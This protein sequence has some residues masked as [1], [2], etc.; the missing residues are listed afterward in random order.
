MKKIIFLLIFLFCLPCQAVE[1][2]IQNIDGSYLEINTT[3]NEV[4]VLENL[5]PYDTDPRKFNKYNGLTYDFKVLGENRYKNKTVYNKE[6]ATSLIKKN[7]AFACPKSLEYKYLLKIKNNIPALPVEQSQL[8]QQQILT[9]VV[10]EIHKTNNYLYLNFG[11]DWKK[12]FSIMVPK[13][14][15]KYLPAQIIGKKVEIRGFVDSYYGNMIKLDNPL[16]LKIIN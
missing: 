5:C 16:F 9:G 1:F 6:L 14:N 15:W 4:L 11:E 10:K 3:R 8:Y 13:E 7:I 12:D 2:T